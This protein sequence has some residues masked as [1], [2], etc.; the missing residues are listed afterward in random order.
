MR[1]ISTRLHGI[2]DYGVG[3]LLI[4]SPLLFGFAVGGPVQWLPIAIGFGIV[5]YSLLTDYELGL[6]PRLSMPLHL[7]LDLAGGALLAASPWLFG[8][9][10]IAFWP[11]LLFGLF[12]IGASLMTERRRGDAPGVQRGEGPADV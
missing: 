3:L 7:G 4:L 8:F 6:S 2:L 1:F 9:A 12:S 5:A 11:H 10:P